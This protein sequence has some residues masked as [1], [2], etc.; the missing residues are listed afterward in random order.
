MRSLSLSREL[1]VV[2]GSL[3]IVFSSVT[4]ALYLLT[5][6]FSYEYPEWLVDLFA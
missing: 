3:A 4:L 2:A 6:R 5:L 1:L